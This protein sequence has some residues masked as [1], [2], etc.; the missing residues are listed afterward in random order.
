MAVYTEVSFKEADTLIDQLNLG[1][2]TSIEACR[3]G[4]ENTKDRKSVV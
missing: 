2:L 3:G 1:R 4:I